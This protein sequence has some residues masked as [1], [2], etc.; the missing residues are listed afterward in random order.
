M[1][2]ILSKTSDVA[3]H[4]WNVV[5]SVG[6]FL[7]AQCDS[8]SEAYARQKARLANVD[9]A[10]EL[11]KGE[12]QAIADARSE[13]I[14]RIPD[15]SPQERVR[16]HQ[17]LE[18][19]SGT[20][21]QLN[22]ATLALE[23]QSQTTSSDSDDAER[24]EVEDHWIDKFNTLARASNEPWREDLLAR[25]LAA[26]S[27]GPG[28]VSP[29]ALWLI[30]TLEKQLFDAYAG[31]LDLCSD[32]GGG[33]MIPKVNDDFMTRLIPDCP[34]QGEVSLGNLSFLLGEIGVLGDPLT[35]KKTVPKGT[36]FLAQYGSSRVVIECSDR[37]LKISGTILSSL[38]KSV[39][40]FYV[41]RFNSLGLEL[42]TAWVEKLRSDEAFLVLDA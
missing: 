30:G 37:D 41:P 8:A 26:E 23:Y 1:N 16:L 17:D 3:G 7:I 25:A 22:V 36:K 35:T 39:S 5:K 31:V 9:A 24:V 38:G 27:S 13:I 15:A 40:K 34:V 33:L 14:G 12:T 42:F 11:I 28:S 32:I 2:D 4:A 19:L 29:R 21:R 20:V 18:F 10:Q 6:P